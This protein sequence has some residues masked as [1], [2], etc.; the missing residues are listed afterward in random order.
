M[1]S[2]IS[3]RIYRPNELYINHMSLK[4]YFCG[5]LFVGAHISVLCQCWDSHSSI[6][7]YLCVLPCRF[8]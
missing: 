5:F 1:L 8:I 6:K 2:G 7:F 3:K 4:F